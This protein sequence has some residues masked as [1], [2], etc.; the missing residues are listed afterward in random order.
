M[1]RQLRRGRLVKMFI[2]LPVDHRQSCISPLFFFNNPTSTNLP[3]FP[4]DSCGSESFRQDNPRP[5]E[6][7]LEGR[8]IQSPIVSCQIP[9]VSRDGLVDSKSCHQHVQLPE[10]GHIPSYDAPVNSTL[11]RFGCRPGQVRGDAKEESCQ[12]SVIPVIGLQ[13]QSTKSGKISP[14]VKHSFPFLT[15]V[16]ILERESLPLNPHYPLEPQSMFR[17]S[18]CPFAKMARH[19]F[20]PPG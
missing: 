6:Q 3:Q 5:S 10:Q 20:P 8:P 11:S 15:T 12:R 18:S 7:F 4:S 14:F 16:C 13:L 2:S 19:S 17:V 9:R 1:E